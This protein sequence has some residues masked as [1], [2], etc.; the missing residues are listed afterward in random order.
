MTPTVII[1]YGV[2]FMVV[3]MCVFVTAC[4]IGLAIATIRSMLE[5]WK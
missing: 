2:A 5:D 3:S 1:E 4:I